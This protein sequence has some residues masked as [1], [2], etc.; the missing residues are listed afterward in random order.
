MV[1]VP[2]TETSRIL[3]DL[4]FVPESDREVGHNTAGVQ[5]GRRPCPHQLHPRSLAKFLAN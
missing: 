2:L 3:V 4:E 1:K 5:T